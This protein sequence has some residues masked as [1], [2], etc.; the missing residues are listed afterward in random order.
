MSNSRTP[1]NY[2][3]SHPIIDEDDEENSFTEQTKESTNKIYENESISS[4]DSRESFENLQKN[5]FQ[6]NR[7]NLNMKYIPKTMTKYVNLY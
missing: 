3:F 2:Y 6:Q 5:R 1:S 7:A 4:D